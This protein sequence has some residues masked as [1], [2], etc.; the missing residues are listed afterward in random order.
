MSSSVGLVIAPLIVWI[1]LF[2][3]MLRLDH[4]VKEL[5]RK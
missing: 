4:Q 2:V 3:F 1:G 5:R